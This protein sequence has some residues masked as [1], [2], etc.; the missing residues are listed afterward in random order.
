VDTYVGLLRG[1]NVGGHNQ[2]KM[3]ALRDML[4]GLGHQDVVTYIQS[5]NVVFDTDG[6]PPDIVRSIETAIETEFGLDI[7]IVLRTPGEL[8]A[9]AEANPYAARADSAR[10]AIAFLKEPPGPDRASATD[11]TAHRPDEFEIVG[12][13]VHLHCPDGFGR[14]KLK[15]AWLEKELGVVSTIRGW[16]TVDRLLTLCRSRTS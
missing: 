11:P 6:D 2:I 16:N 12:S 13:E 7:A 3:A 1:I 8:A 9:A 14:S 5:G 15:N 4:G 10:V